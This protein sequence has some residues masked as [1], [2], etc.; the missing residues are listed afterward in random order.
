VPDAAVADP[1]GFNAG[2]AGGFDVVLP[3]TDHP[4]VGLGHR[5]FA[6]GKLEGDGA[7][8]EGTVLTRDNCVKTQGVAAQHKFDASAAV[9]G[10]QRCGNR[11]SAQVV[12]QLAASGVERGILRG[13][14]LVT[15]QDRLGLSPKLGRHFGQ[16]LEDG[17]SADAH[18]GLDLREIEHRLGQRAIHIEEDGAGKG[19]LRHVHPVELL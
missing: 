1:D 14:I 6:A 16:G 10:D 5:K 2:G 9:A 17:A 19:V 4:S 11:V 13:M 7:G 18:L 3:V 8:F 15:Q 12:K